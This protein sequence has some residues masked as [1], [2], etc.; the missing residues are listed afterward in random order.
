MVD[1]RAL[2]KGKGQ[3]RRPPKEIK[4]CPKGKE[5][6]QTTKEGSV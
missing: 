1:G 2:G 4:A 3:E 5:K 6:T